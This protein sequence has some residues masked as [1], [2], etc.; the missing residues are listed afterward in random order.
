MQ[1]V[2]RVQPSAI[3]EGFATVPGVTWEDVGALCD[4]REELSFAISQPIANPER[5]AAMGLNVAVGVL[6]FGACRSASMHG[7]S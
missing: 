6:L 1:A 4:V 2:K 3:R 7:R 5:F